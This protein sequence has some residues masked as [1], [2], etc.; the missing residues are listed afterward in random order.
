MQLSRLTVSEMLTISRPY[1]DPEHPAHQSLAKMPEA[2]SLL[3]RLREAH[4]VLLAS[5]SADDVRAA[6]IKQE[7]TALEAEHDDLAM[8]IHH[9]VHSMAVLSETDDARARWQ[10]LHEVLLPG[11]G[12]FASTSHKTEAGNAA[13]LQQILEGLSAI[14]TGLMKAQFVA[15]RSI[16]EIVE[17]WIEVGRELGQKELERRA[18]PV[19][20]TDDTLQASKGQWVKTIGAISAM[21]KMAELLGELPSDVKQH[22]MT[23]LHAATERRGPRRSLLNLEAVV[24]Q[25]A[26][27]GPN[28]T[29]GEKS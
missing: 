25:A 14:D 20:T 9:I 2:V 23:P 24:P 11:S 7:V 21:M 6:N 17:R 13:L 16:F 19:A 29:G 10:R 15:K 4:E 22:V 18:M 28:K 27:T 3:P 5:Q 1:L 12:K 26:P 8:G